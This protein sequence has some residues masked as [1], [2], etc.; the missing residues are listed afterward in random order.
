M[1]AWKLSELKFVLMFV[2]ILF[3]IF[4]AYF[5]N[6]RVLNVISKS[7]YAGAQHKISNVLEWP[8]KEL[9]NIFVS[10]E[11]RNGICCCFSFDDTHF[12]TCVK[13][14]RLLLMCL[15]SFILASVMTGLPFLTLLVDLSLVSPPLGFPKVPYVDPWFLYSNISLSFPARSTKFN[16][17]SFS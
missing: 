11:F 7:F 4:L 10:G 9:R 3:S 8:P 12:I 13:K 14:N 16:S 2:L 15:L 1:M 17:D 5:P 6:L